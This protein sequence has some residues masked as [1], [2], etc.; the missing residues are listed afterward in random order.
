MAASGCGTGTHGGGEERA[1]SPCSHGDG[2][3]GAGESLDIVSEGVLQEEA[4]FLFGLITAR[5]NV[6]YL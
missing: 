3:F 6:V 1:L 5:I 2:G 4:L